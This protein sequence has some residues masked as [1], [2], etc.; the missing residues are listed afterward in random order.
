MY[1]HKENMT[2]CFFRGREDLWLYMS[3]NL[4]QPTVRVDGVGTHADKLQ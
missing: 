1:N 4:R 3:N 2:L